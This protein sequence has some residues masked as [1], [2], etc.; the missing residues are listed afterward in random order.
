MC[1]CP[2]EQGFWYSGHWPRHSA[3]FTKLFWK[4]EYVFIY[5]K[6]NLKI[7]IFHKNQN[8]NPKNPLDTHLI[9]ASTGVGEA[10]T[11]LRVRVKVPSRQ[12]GVA[13][14]SREWHAARVAR[15]TFTIERVSR[16]RAGF[17]W[18]SVQFHLKTTGTVESHDLKKMTMSDMYGML[19]EDFVTH[20][21]LRVSWLSDGVIAEYSM[22]LIQIAVLLQI[23]HR[24]DSRDCL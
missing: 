17:D 6:K 22:S 7:N 8:P 24:R 3:R 15:C 9:A 20:A 21:A 4:C 19:I 1:G 12:D 13:I 2:V 23:T 14:A 11:C 10:E 16:F 5:V 18:V